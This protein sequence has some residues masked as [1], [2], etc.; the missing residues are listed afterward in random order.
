MT[1]VLQDWKIVVN[2]RPV[3]NISAGAYVFLPL[4]PGLNTITVKAGLRY[5][6]PLSITVEQGQITNLEAG[7]NDDKIRGEVLKVNRESLYLVQ[8]PV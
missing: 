1:G 4:Q 7:M 2:D 6:A 3:Q 8:R 5:S